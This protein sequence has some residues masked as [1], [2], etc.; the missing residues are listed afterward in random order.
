MEAEVS[1]SE[2]PAFFSRMSVYTPLCTG[3][4]VAQAPGTV[5]PARFSAILVVLTL[6]SRSIR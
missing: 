4:F 3:V 1:G 5:V 2:V 6:R